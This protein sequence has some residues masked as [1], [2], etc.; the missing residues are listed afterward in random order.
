MTLSISSRASI[1]ALAL[2]VAACGFGDR[3]SSST[4]NGSVDTLP[5]GRIVV[6]NPD[7]P[8]S[9]EKWT[10]EERFRVG[11]LEGDGYDVF[12]DIGGLEI[13]PTGELYVLDD[14][15][16]EVR[17]FSSDGIF[18][19]TMGREGQGP[20]EF[21]NPSGLAL[22]SYGTIWVLNWGNGRYTGF[23]PN[24]G[25]VRREPIRLA[26]FGIFP[27][28][29]KFENGARLIDVGLNAEGRP[30]ILRLDTA[31]VPSDTLVLPAPAT[32]DRIA[33]RREGVM[34]GA[35][36]VPFAHRPSWAPRPLG[37]IVMGEGSQYRLH[38]I[39]F[40]GDTTMT[41]ELARDL[42]P[43]S[44][45]ERDSALADFQERAER[46]VNAAPERRPSVREHKPAH[47][48]VVVD[49]RDR[50]WVRSDPQS[51]EVYTWDV[52]DSDGRFIVKV[53]IPESVGFSR[54]VSGFSRPVFRDDRMAIGTQAEG[55]PV[56]IVYDL[57]REAR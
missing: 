55:F 38:R 15:S 14:Q 17:V 52:F 4:W 7:V 23:D 19:R 56:V 41:I 16:Y 53:D 46:F 49:D 27:W 42:V 9:H 50:I 33:F 26:S 40:D 20:G 45:E 10:F 12:G 30:S 24:T 44:Q 2:V 21:R 1:A 5:S 6:R 34:V 29:G 36:M 31:F 47:G 8:A 11:S 13:G 35:M 54:P 51:G 22:D 39:D 48:S 32:E 37:G 57:T 43:I 28:P 25:D 3:P 18:Q